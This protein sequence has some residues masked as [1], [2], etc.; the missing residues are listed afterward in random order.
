MAKKR[1]RRWRPS[2][3]EKLE[4]C[5]MYKGSAF[6]TAV[7]AEGT[8]LHSVMEAWVNTGKIPRELL[9]QMTDEHHA[10]IR[11]CQEHVGELMVNATRFATET[12]VKIYTSGNIRIRGTIDLIIEYR[13]S[14][15]IIID[16]KFGRLPVT[17]ASENLQGMAYALG[18]LLEN[19]S[20]KEVMLQFLEPHQQRVTAAVMTRD[21]IPKVISRIAAVIAKCRSKLGQEP[22][23]HPTACQYCSRKTT[24]S[25]LAKQ[26]IAVAEGHTGLKIPTR[27]LPGPDTTP[28]QRNLA[29]HLAGI[30]ADW[31]TMWKKD[32]TNAVIED[33]IELPDFEL[34]SRAGSRQILD[35]NA[36]WL[37]LET[38]GVP[39][40][41]FLSACSVSVG[42]L[43]KT[44]AELEKGDSHALKDR[45]YDELE[46]A[47]IL[48][49]RNPAVFLQRKAK[50]T[51]EN[52]LT[53][54]AE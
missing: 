15:P 16:Y 14:S 44:I 34:R 27:F 1:M 33:G 18:Y 46:N 25:A 48:V 52:L 41:H 8:M 51:F 42:A 24:C 29:Q 9:K 47:G 11:I 19:P 23:V 50:R 36:A 12:R 40:P 26:A 53:E 5:S 28:E 13:G 49:S 43:D 54:G 35:A 20:V 4:L 37:I 21:D 7:S 31:G 22:K 45:C 38:L 6:D 32:N 10:L 39:L 17:P 30:L 2:E 3:L